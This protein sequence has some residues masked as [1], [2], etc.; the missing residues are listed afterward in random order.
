MSK[1]E[2][3]VYTASGMEFYGNR[4]E[5][6]LDYYQDPDNDNKAVLGFMYRGDLYR[7]E[8]F[9]ITSRDMPFDGFSSDTYFSGVAIQLC[10][11][12]DYVRA[13]LGFAK[14]SFEVDPRRYDT[15]IYEEGGNIIRQNEG[16]RVVLDYVR[17][18]YDYPQRVMITSA[19]ENMRYKVIFYLRSGARIEA[20]FADPTVAAEWVKARRSWGSVKSVVPGFNNSTIMWL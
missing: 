5:I 12:N 3:A 19:D 4:H 18:A 2:K 20:W 9:E 1:L 15:R 10:G 6:M 8:D 17:E 7:M 14:S 11:D 16:L 13:F